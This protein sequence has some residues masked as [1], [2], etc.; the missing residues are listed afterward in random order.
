MRITGGIHRSRTLLTPKNNAVRPTSDK[1]RQAVFYMLN[2]RGL[3]KNAVVIDAFCGTGALGLESLSQGALHC[4]FFDKSKNA[5]ALA[6]KNIQ[7]LNEEVRS[8]LILQDA[9]TV[10]PCPENI[11]RATL[12]FIDPPYHKNLVVQAVEAL[13]NKFW[14]ANDAYFYY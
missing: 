5:V 8:T 10:K 3:V 6:K 4:T 14:L 13:Q 12:V 7:I 9:T 11:K 2:A 1:I